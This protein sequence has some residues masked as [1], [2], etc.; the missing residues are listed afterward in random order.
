MIAAIRWIEL[1]EGGRQGIPEG[2]SYVAPACFDGHS[3]FPD[4][5]WSLR[6]ETT[7]GQKFALTDRV[8]VQFLVRNAP[9]HWL[10]V[11]TS[12]SMYEGRRKV[13]E[14]IIESE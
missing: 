9:H 3:R 6:I 5:S 13:V 2:C 11:G 8:I 1:E 4:C 14:G 10:T 7:S 12:F